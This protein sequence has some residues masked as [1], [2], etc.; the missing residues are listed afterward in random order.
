MS[1]HFF[2]VLRVQT[3]SFAK[4][5]LYLIFFNYL[6][7]KHMNLRMNAESIAFYDSSKNELNSLNSL[8]ERLICNKN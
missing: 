6:R 8:F 3:H 2:S 7:F 4:K 1:L 5:Y